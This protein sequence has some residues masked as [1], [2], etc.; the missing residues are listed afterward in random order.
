MNPPYYN[1]FTQEFVLCKMPNLCAF[2]RAHCELRFSP[3]PDTEL[4][5]RRVAL[6]KGWEI[7]R[8]L[9]GV[10]NLPDLR[11]AAAATAVCGIPEAQAWHPDRPGS[12]HGTSPPEQPAEPVLAS[13][14][15][16]AMWLSATQGACGT[17][18][19]TDSPPYCRS[20]GPVPQRG[21]R[22]PSARSAWVPAPNAHIDRQTS[23]RPGGFQSA[24]S[25]PLGAVRC[26]GTPFLVNRLW[27]METF[28][29][30]PQLR[31]WPASLRESAQ[32]RLSLPVAVL[33][34]RAGRPGYCT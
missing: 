21:T 32:G 14:M 28:N 2:V 7:P 9:I 4:G 34:L 13:T 18:L 15:R 5:S 29:R 19:P 10:G 33:P 25:D 31:R 6:R 1:R 20:W 12:V 8:N 27:I 17:P 24:D 26:S 3:V 16:R 22:L 30:L 11:P 23:D